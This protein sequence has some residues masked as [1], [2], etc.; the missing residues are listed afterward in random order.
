MQKRKQS[1][2]L[3]PQNSYP[4]KK[5]HF[6][7]MQKTIVKYV[8]GISESAS[9]YQKKQHKKYG[10]NMDLSAGISTLILDMELREKKSLH[11]LIK[12]EMIPHFLIYE[13]AK[14]AKKESENCR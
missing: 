10:G 13:K 8:S 7:H 9:S 14:V 4:M 6:E 2:S 3:V 5:W 1:N 11:F 12:S